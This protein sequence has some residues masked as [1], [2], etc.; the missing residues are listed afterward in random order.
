MDTEALLRLATHLEGRGLRVTVNE[1]ERRLHVTNP[2][3]D[4]L[5]EEI[6]AT[7]DRYVTSFGYEIG[8]HG[9]ERACAERLAQLLAVGPATDT[10]P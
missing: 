2:L 5:T 4:M 8:E 1:A 7:G 9:H 3:N 10:A 6:V